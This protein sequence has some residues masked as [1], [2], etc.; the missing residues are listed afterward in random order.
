MV[1]GN[2]RGCVSDPG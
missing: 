1:A 2:L